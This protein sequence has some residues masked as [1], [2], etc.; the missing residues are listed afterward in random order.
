M[1]VYIL[2]TNNCSIP[3]LTFLIE[4]EEGNGQPVAFGLLAREDQQHV[5]CFKGFSPK[6]MTSQEW[7]V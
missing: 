5:E 4:D 3:L 2:Q 6:T 1:N 7:N